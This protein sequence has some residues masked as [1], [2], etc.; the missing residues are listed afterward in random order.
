MFNVLFKWCH[1]HHDSLDFFQSCC[2]KNFWLVRTIVLSK[3][4]RTSFFLPRLSRERPF[5]KNYLST[6]VKRIF[7]F[8]ESFFEPLNFSDSPVPQK[9]L[10]IFVKRPSIKNDSVFLVKLFFLTFFK[11]LFS[12]HS[13]MTFATRSWKG[14]LLRHFM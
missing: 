12:F 13:R 2:Q 4:Q 6:S 7:Y 3:F 1:F 9:E 14:R 5:I 10:R 11:K 8:F